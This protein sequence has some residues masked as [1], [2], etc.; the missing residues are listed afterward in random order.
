MRK[1]LAHIGLFQNTHL[2]VK[3]EQKEENEKE[4]GGKRREMTEKGMETTQMLGL[5]GSANSVYYPFNIHLV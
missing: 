4:N 2:G 5:E 3:R 1:L